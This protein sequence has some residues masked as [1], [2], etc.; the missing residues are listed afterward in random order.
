MTI[1]Y[2]KTRTSPCDPTTLPITQLSVSLRQASRMTGLSERTLRRL[3]AR[4]T[5]QSKKVGARRVVSFDALSKLV[6]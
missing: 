5:L 6:T 1:S 4:G 3:V 2:M